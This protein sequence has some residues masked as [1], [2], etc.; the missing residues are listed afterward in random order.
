MAYRLR[1]SGGAEVPLQVDARGQA[2]FVL[3]DLEAGALKTYRIEVRQGAPAADPG[4]AASRED[5]VVR[6][7]WEGRPVLRYQGGKGVLPPD[8][9][10]PAF[11]RGGYIHPVF[12]PSG[13]VV[14]DDYPPDHRH[15]HGIWLAWTRT[16]FEGR[17]PDFWNMG[18]GTGTVEFE[19]LDETWSGPVHGGLRARHR[20]VDLSA[21]TPATALK[22][23]WEAR[24]YA[25]GRAARP[26]ALFDLEVRQECARP[27]PLVLPE[28]HYGGV[29]FRGPRQWRG[30]AGAFFLTSEAKDRSNGHAT[31]ARW[32][33]ISGRV[34]GEIAGVAIL[35]HPANFRA[36][37]PMR[38]HPDEPFFCFAP[39][40]LGRWEIAPGPA[41]VS[42][43]RFVAFDGA[44]DPREL[45]RLWNDYAEPPRA[46][47]K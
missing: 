5:E 33:H 35:G 45:D 25:V 15:H 41:Y 17:R 44:P 42:R 12:T 3:K 30:A 47:V 23:T 14:T 21:A 2:W 22:E 27:S 26:Y 20:Y 24:A 7:V 40:Q 4:V 19:S 38:I 29:G 8:D 31:R 11:R 6:I 16:E 13:R 10:K 39:S 43:Y 28:Y 34:D 32:C 37:Q 9:T 36:P 18:D 1:E 46:T